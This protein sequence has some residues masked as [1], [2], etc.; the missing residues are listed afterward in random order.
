MQQPLWL[1]HNYVAHT[2]WRTLRNMHHN[3]CY[4]QQ[5]SAV[6]FLTLQTLSQLSRSACHC[7]RTSL[8]VSDSRF[9]PYYN[10]FIFTRKF[11]A[12]FSK[13][14][15][16]EYILKHNYFKII[17]KVLFVFYLQICVSSSVCAVQTTRR[18]RA[19]QCVCFLE[20][21]RHKNV[22]AWSSWCRLGLMSSHLFTPKQNLKT[23]IK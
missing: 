9:L 16:G 21:R 5:D 1:M 15:R 8:E 23:K 7:P 12:L 14:F 6:P 13:P 19:L 11:T 20:V 4:Q 2:S 18:H 17:T 10:D 22:C 3:N